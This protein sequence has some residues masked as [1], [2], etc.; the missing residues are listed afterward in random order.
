MGHE[1]WQIADDFNV[2][3]VSITLQREPLAE[4]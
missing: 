2:A 4:E 3:I 1:D